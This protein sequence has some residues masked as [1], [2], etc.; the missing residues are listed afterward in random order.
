MF[1]IIKRYVSERYMQFKDGQIWF[2]KERIAFY[3]VPHLTNEF[4]INYE[5]YSLDYCANIFLAGR[6]Q[7]KTFVEQHGVPLMKGLTLVVK[8]SCEI[9]NTFGFGTFRTIKV[10]DKEGFMVL[11]GN[12]TLASD[13]KLNKPS[14]IPTDFMLGGLFAGALQHYSKEPMY[15]VETAC[16]AQKDL[17]ECCWVIGSKS[18]IMD[19]VKKFSPDKVAWSDKIIGRITEAE[20]EFEEKGNTEWT[21][22]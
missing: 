8:M 9:L 15:A 1:D 4:D 20:K 19:Y 10:D 21:T 18:G 17:Q 3:F 11:V 6:K 7:G 2:G 22:C 14:K 5:R 16:V 13:I 12:S